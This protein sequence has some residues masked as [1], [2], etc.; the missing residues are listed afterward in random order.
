MTW[1]LSSANAAVASFYIKFCFFINPHLWNFGIPY[2]ISWTKGASIGWHSDD[3]RHYL[4]QRDFTVC[5]A[6]MYIIF[7]ISKLLMS[8]C[9]CIDW[10]LK[11][12][13]CW[14]QR[15][16]QYWFEKIWKYIN[17]EWNIILFWLTKIYRF[18]M[19]L[20]EM[21]IHEINCCSSLHLHSSVMSCW[22]VPLGLQI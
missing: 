11:I 9:Q 15:K 21:L 12:Q 17:F 3:N 19:V 18:Q 2:I 20:C 22:L 10:D 8:C 4:K 1:W 16:Y 14:W 5:I 6:V 13:L 7:I